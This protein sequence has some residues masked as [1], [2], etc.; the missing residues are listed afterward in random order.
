MFYVLAFFLYKTCLSV[1]HYTHMCM[2]PV[3]DPLGLELQT[4]V[5]HNVAVLLHWLCFSSGL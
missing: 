3:S 2:V 5:S 4:A 1:H